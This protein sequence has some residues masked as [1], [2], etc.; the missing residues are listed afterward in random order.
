MSDSV[1]PH[2]WQPTRLCHP[3]DSPGK[4]TGV[5]CHFLL[6][7]KTLC[8]LNIWKYL[9][10]KVCPLVLG[11]GERKSCVVQFSLHLLICSGL[12]W[13]SLLCAGFLWLPWA[14]DHPSLLA[15]RGL[16]ASV[17]SLVQSTGSR[18]LG[19][20]SLWRVCSA[21]VTLRLTCPAPR[22]IIPGQ[23]WNPCPLHW[24][25]LNHWTTKEVPQ[26]MVLIKRY[27]N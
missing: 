3:G 11:G 14:W 7:I 5:G 10:I 20:Q 16:P 12:S 9:F 18:L 13:S 17:A 21:V 19:L 24:Q 22:G 15:V 27:S 23:G 1:G 26:W 25:I 8:I 6:Q 2:R 4:N